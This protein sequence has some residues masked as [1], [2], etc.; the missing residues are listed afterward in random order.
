MPVQCTIQCGAFNLRLLLRRCSRFCECVLVSSF[1]R[2]LYPHARWFVA[3]A[4]VNNLR[5]AKKKSH[6]FVDVCGA[7][8]LK[9]RSDR[10][11]LDPL[12]TVQRT[13][14]ISCSTLCVSPSSSLSADERT[15]TGRRYTKRHHHHQRDTDEIWSMHTPNL[16]IAPRSPPP[17]FHTALSERWL[18]AVRERRRDSRFFFQFS[19]GW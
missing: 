15:R 19:G 8:F 18:I 4:Y 17:S 10:S 14:D 16:D 9:Q 3:N 2:Y 11:R 5:V 13:F 1:T 12:T 7:R 6:T